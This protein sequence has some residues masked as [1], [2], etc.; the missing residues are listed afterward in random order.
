MTPTASRT[1]PEVHDHAAVGPPH[2]AAPPTDVAGAGRPH[3]EDEGAGRGG[4]GHGAEA[5][6]DE[7]GEAAQ[8]EGDA[9]HDG[10][11]ADPHRDG[12]PLP[13]HAAAH[14]APAQDRRHGHEEEQGQ[15]DRDGDGVEER[16]A[17]AHLLLGDRLVEKRVEGAEQH[18]EGESDEEHVV[19]EE[20]ALA[21]E[22]GVDT[23][24]RAQAVAAPGD[25]AEPH[26]DHGEE[27]A[28]Q[29]RARGRTRR[30]R[31]PT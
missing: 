21:P 14:L 7:R 1:T 30:T 3:G 11:H 16:R 9:Q 22:R 13:Q 28:D 4:G 15:A 18:D 5:E 12:Q 6:A 29:Q 17:D 10:A 31:G 19:E 20:R 25:Q 26:D 23:P 24:R 27:E 8:A 2:Q